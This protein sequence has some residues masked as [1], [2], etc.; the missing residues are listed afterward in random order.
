VPSGAAASP[1]RAAAEYDELVG[2]L[3][4]QLQILGIGNN[5]HIGFN[6]PGSAFDSR[7]RVVALTPATRQSNARF[8]ADISEVPT[9][10]V[11]QGIGTILDAE[12]LLLLATGEG[13]QEALAR[14]M[15]GPVS[16]D[17]PASA[18]QLHGHV[19]VVADA[20]AAPAV[21]P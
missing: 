14:A 13:K 5:G 11:T 19:T 7:T 17:C 8:F 3:G 18:L 16:R 1:T 2:R 12:S 9:H 6:E 20:A 10:A 15:S 21:R 4:V